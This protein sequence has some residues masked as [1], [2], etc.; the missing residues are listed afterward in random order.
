[1]APSLYR[2]LLLIARFLSRAFER[3]DSK[4]A[5]G[6]RGRR[7]S[8]G[9]LSDWGSQYRDHRR[10]VAWFHAPS[11]GEALLARTVIDALRARDPTVQIVFTYFSPSAE[12]PVA[13]LGADVATYLPWDLPGPVGAA[14]DAVKP[15]VLVFSKTEVWPTLVAAAAARGVPTALVG[16]TVPDGAGRLTWPARYVMRRTW[17]ELAFAGA[18]GASDRARLVQLGVR[19]ERV[20]LTGDPSFDSAV[21]RFRK[22]DPAAPWL[23]PLLQDRAPTVVGGSIWPADEEV[24]LPALNDA[25]TRIR[26]LRVVL[27]PHE[28]DPATVSSLLSKLGRDGWTASTL[29]AVEAAAGT[30]DAD[31][32][33]VDRVGVLGHLYRVAD[34]SFVGGGFDRQGLHSVLEPAA[35]ASPV[36]FGPFGAGSPAAEAL[37]R[38]GGAKIARNAAEL[39]D[40]ILGWLVDPAN[41]KG[42]GQSAQ[43]YIQGQIGA[44]DRSA[45][46]IVNLMKAPREQP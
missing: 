42:V 14:L 40:T 3:G 43:D 17:P 21:S 24:L 35:A 2:L 19:P 18:V 32:V 22:L 20:V 34:V 28:P 27:V 46:Q 45:D 11:V 23:A 9:E 12:A 25:R 44:A 39:T 36:V 6:L 33:V 29:S 16:A 5:Q 30:G 8:S 13:L 7:R 1:M 31:A 10:P 38:I 41:G 15:D 4:L 37:V 26:G